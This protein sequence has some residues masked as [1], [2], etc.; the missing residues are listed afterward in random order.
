MVSGST[1]PQTG[2]TFRFI[3]FIIVMATLVFAIVKGQ[4]DRSKTPQPTPSVTVT[5]VK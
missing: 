1:A 2:N 3:M 5:A 4:S